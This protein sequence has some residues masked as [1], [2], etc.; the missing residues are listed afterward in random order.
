MIVIEDKTEEEGEDLCIRGIIAGE[1]M[2]TMEEGTII[3][4]MT[5]VG[6]TAMK[7]EAEAEAG[8]EVTA[9]RR[10]TAEEGVIVTPD[11]EVVVLTVQAVVVAIAEIGAPAEAALLKEQA[12]EMIDMIEEDPKQGAVITRV[13]RK[14][15]TGA[16][17]GGRERA[18]M[19][20]LT[21][22]STDR[23]V[24]YLGTRVEIEREVGAWKRS[25]MVPGENAVKV[26]APEKRRE[27]N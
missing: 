8:I 1:E 9:E 12:L 26:G 24:K 14:M 21:D 19:K 2:I 20:D 18:V 16:E 3:T 17:A 15:N 7:I 25:A 13:T 4:N 6:E 27:E 10:V 23:E 11:G 22:E 5:A